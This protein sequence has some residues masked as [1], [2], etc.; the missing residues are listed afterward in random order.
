MRQTH[1]GCGSGHEDTGLWTVS[2]GV[3]HTAGPNATWKRHSWASTRESVLPISH[4]INEPT[5]VAG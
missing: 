1:E 3:R 4:R 5:T 2:A